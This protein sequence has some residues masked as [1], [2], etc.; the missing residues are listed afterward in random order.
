[1]SKPAINPKKTAAGIAVDPQSLDRVVPESRRPDGSVRKEIKI[2]PGFTPQEDVSRFRG[3]R[4]VQMDRNALPKG[5]ILGWVAPSTAQK[6]DQESKPMSKSAKKNAK[7]KQ[8]RE[9]KRNEIIKDNWED[10]DEDASP[11]P[12]APTQLSKSSSSTSNPA[13]TAD[14]PNWAVAS[15]AEPPSK[16]T[17][18]KSDADSLTKDM[19]KLEV[20]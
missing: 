12:K 14:T 3:S 10:E 16:D 7:R 18:S 4:Q 9:E 2:R 20:K 6:E 15:D 11:P 17:S 13:H 5:H 8:Q 19:D 1:M